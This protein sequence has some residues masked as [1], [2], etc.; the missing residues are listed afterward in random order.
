MKRQLASGSAY[1]IKPS[2]SQLGKDSPTTDN[3]CFVRGRDSAHSRHPCVTGRHRFVL[4][5]P[6]AH[7]GIRHIRGTKPSK[8]AG[9]ELNST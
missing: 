4:F 9:A 3:M 1:C 8:S 7:F 2:G 6:L 5:P